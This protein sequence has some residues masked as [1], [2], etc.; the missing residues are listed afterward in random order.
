MF[1]TISG[2]QAT[3][4]AHV[5]LL[6]MKHIIS[7]LLY[8][9]IL[10]CLSVFVFDPTN[11]YYEIWWLDI[12]MH[13]MGGFGVVSLALSV[14][15]YKKTNLTFTQLLIL[16]VVVAVAWELYECVGDLLRGD[17]WNGWSDSVSDFIN[18]AVGAVGAYYLLKK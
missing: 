5:I 3:I 2:P 9:V 15:S 6:L 17:A 1:F 18:G 12:P 8:L 14:A 13:I 4:L 11:L 7:S 16:Y 10:L